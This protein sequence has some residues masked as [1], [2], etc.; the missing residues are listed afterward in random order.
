MTRTI[1]LALLILT[2]C[3]PTLSQS[4]R[5]VRSV[6]SA[7][8]CEHAG[9]YTGSSWL[10][11]WF[12]PAESRARGEAIEKAAAAGVSHVVWV[13]SREGLTGGNAVANGYRC[14]E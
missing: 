14:A 12:F 3:A 6:Q 1:I 4:A 11:G 7:P 13:E 9:T 10:N 8:R 5:D 2:G